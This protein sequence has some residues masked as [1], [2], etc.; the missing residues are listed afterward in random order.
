MPPIKQAPVSAATL[1]AYRAALARKADKL[2]TADI[3]KATLTP[4]DLDKKLTGA[5]VKFHAEDAAGNKFTFKPYEAG[6]T[7]FQ[8][9]HFAGTLRAEAGEAVVRVIPQT[10]TLPSG[11]KLEGY[12]KPK[13]GKSEELP[14]DPAKWSD[15]QR[16]EL[17]AD[18][19]WAEF[20]GNYDLKLDQYASVALNDDLTQ[21]ALIDGDWDV[22]LSDYEHP[23]DL[24]R[25]KAFKVGLAA[26]N[27]V[28]AA[29]PTQNL[30]YESYVHGK[31]DLDFAP[32]YAAIGRIEALPEK[33]I[34]AA[35]APF[36]AARF[37]EGKPFGEYKTGE[38]LVQGVL[39]RQ[40]TL[41]TTFQDFEG[42]LKSERKHYDERSLPNLKD[43]KTMIQEDWM[44][45]GNWFVQSPLLGW[46]N[47]HSQRKEA[48]K[49]GIKVG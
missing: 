5:N 45:L 24:N 1:D 44:H 14:S 34:R 11:Q 2:P 7:N 36:I 40:K 22:S 48:E 43:A 35:L 46:M 39:L 47:R 23:S 10:L 37:A 3:A 38:E 13:F 18:A 6:S 20:L 31:I 16:A 17:L 28:P 32:M 42:A 33:D 25:F 8:R 26:K 29:P 30:M 12:V 27:I 9:D 21:K 41:R 15:V 4:T 19:P 49:L